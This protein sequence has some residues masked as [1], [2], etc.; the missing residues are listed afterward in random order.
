M[1]GGGEGTTAHVSGKTNVQLLGGLVKGDI[2]GGGDAGAMPLM[3]EAIKG[4]SQGE[5]T[6]ATLCAIEDGQARKVFGGGLN[7]DIAG[8]THVIIGST[9]GTTLASGKPAIHRNV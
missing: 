4:Y 7:G 6:I 3:T 9:Q 2:Y 8:N 1:F 5:Q